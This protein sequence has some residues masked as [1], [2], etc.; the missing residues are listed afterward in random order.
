MLDILSFVKCEKEKSNI[1]ALYLF[2]QHQQLF[3]KTFF[4]VH[5]PANNFN[6]FDVVSPAYGYIESALV[7]CSNE[8]GLGPRHNMKRD[9]GSSIFNR[10]VVYYLHLLTPF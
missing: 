1:T 10:Q 6:M 5:K 3:V 9:H 2:Q 4:L 8:G 7:K